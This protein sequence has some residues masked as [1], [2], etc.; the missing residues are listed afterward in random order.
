MA[1]M[2]SKTSRHQQTSLKL[3]F[4]HTYTFSP[5]IASGCHH[6]REGMTNTLPISVCIESFFMILL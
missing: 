2:E 5:G 4:A 3:A 6:F 1:S